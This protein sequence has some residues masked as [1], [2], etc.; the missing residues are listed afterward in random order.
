MCGTYLVVPHDNSEVRK[1]IGETQQVTRAAASRSEDISFA[2]N[3]GRVLLKHVS[4]LVVEHQ[5]L[6]GDAC[7]ALYC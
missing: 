3:L 4:C 2:T 1:V 5:A 6:P 7:H